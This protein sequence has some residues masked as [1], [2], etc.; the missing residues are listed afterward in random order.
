MALHAWREGTRKSY[1]CYIVQWII[2]RDFHKFDPYEPS[3]RNVTDFLRLLLEDGASYSTINIARCALSAVLYTGSNETIRSHPMVSLVVK[4]CGNLNP[5]QPKYDITWDVSLI[6]KL[7]HQLGRNS[8]LSLLRLSQK[9]TVLLLLCTAQ[10]G[11]TIWYFRLLGM[12]YT[13]FGVRFHMQHQLKHKKTWGTVK[14]HKSSI[15]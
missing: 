2:F 6:F 5:P 4:G 14:F 12:K 7:F 8:E 15:L 13:D 9:L 10:C 11:Q 1:R 3:I